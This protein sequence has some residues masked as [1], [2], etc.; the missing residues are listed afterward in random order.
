ML[1]LLL[2]AALAADAGDARPSPDAVPEAAARRPHVLRDA[3][4]AAGASAVVALGKPD[5]RRAI[6][7]DGRFRNIADNFADP[8]GRIREGT[9][10]DTDPFW[11]NNI[12]HPLSFGVE[13]LYL[14]HQGYSDGHAF[15]FTQVHSVVWEFV[16]EGS[17]F[18]PSGKD[19]IADAAGAAVAIWIVRPL[20]GR[21]RGPR[22][23]AEHAV[24]QIAPVPHGM[25]LRLVWRP[26]W[27]DR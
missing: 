27:G 26:Q 22:A 19:L 1:A 12:A 11:V 6:L 20:L 24:F 23:P 18:P 9:R 13:A 25:E 10:R 3:A 16:I 5:I 4:L 2:T 8:I 14:K 15:L 21:I 7:Q 17:A